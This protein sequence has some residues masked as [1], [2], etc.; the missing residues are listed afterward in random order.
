MSRGGRRA[1]RVQR[2]AARLRR[3]FVQFGR[4]W[5]WGT[6]P[7][8][9]SPVALHLLPMVVVHK[10]AAVG[11]S[12]T[13]SFVTIEEAEFDCWGRRFVVSVHPGPEI[14]VRALQCFGSPEEI[15]GQCRTLAERIGERMLQEMADRFD[16]EMIHGPGR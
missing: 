5:T 4:E 7:T 9:Y 13:D 15:R 8:D 11:K 1:H 14:R 2:R 10:G 3:S 16:R 12:E 6:T